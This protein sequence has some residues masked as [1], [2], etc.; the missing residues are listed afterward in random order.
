[1]INNLIINSATVDDIDFIIEAI[2]ESDKSSTNV[3]SACNIFC[4]SEEEYRSVL[5]QILLEDFPNSE[6]SLGGFQVAR[7]D[8]QK[9]GAL[10][11]WVENADGIS[12]AIIKSSLLMNFIEKEKLV[13]TGKKLEIINGMSFE[14]QPN[15]IQIEYGY[16]IASRRRKKIFTQ[17]ILSSL[18]KHV[19]FETGVTNV[20]TVLFEKNIN[21]FDAFAKLQFK[22]KQKKMVADLD[23][24]N[25][26]PYNAKVLMNI[27]LKDKREYL[28]KLI[29][30]FIFH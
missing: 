5:K 14:R 12:N 4:M 17:L 23:A 2:I 19:N 6:Y 15:C 1:M 22:V 8:G 7:V 16:V 13:S 3:I 11:S 28:E 9:V 27:E 10:C 30:Q 20:E 26:F 18:K 25:I 29:E 21:S 24:Y